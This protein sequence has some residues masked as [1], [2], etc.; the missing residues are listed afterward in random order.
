M[1]TWAKRVLQAVDLELARIAQQS[2]TGAEG[3][4]LLL[5]AGD[6]PIGNVQEDLQQLRG[7][8]LALWDAS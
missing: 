7:D 5:P 1:P 6:S 2:S 4:K 8:V 3:S